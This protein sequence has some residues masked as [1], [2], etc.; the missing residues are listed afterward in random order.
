AGQTITFGTLAN[1]NY[2]DAPFSVGATASSGLA[3]S[4]SIFSGPATTS[5]T[6]VTITGA[7]TVIV[8][9]SQAGDTNYN[10]A[11][12]L[13]QSFTVAPANQTIAFGALANK[14]YGDALFS[15]SA[16]AS[17]GLPVS[18]SVFSGPAT[19]S[20]TNVTITGA[21][22][23]VVRASQAGN[24]NYNAAPNVDQSFAVAKADQ[25]ITFDSLPNKALGESAFA[26]TA[27]ASS[28]LPVSFSILSGPATIS[29]GTVALTNTGTVVV[30]ASQ[31][32]D[33]DYNAASNVDQTFTAYPPPS[34]SLAASDQ[35]V[36]LSWTTNVAGF[37]LL[38]AT[39]LAPGGSWTPV[40]PAPVVVN[41]QYVV[42]NAAS[43]TLKF[44]RLKK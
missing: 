30:R 26:V 9:A 24:T 21:G 14:N 5:G 8:R 6:N 15:V 44:Y 16:T 1:K 11:P 7:G 12:N 27:T 38:S 39:D 42:T 43:G 28:G 4:F 34:L 20:G 17:S 32:G 18:F 41:G 35:D 19:I 2:G 33:A 29:A 37:T 25:T 22:T 13:D 23:V 40:V 36:V 31:A 10:A 3:V